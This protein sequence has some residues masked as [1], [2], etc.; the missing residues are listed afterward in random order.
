MSKLIETPDTIELTSKA[1]Q[2]ISRA[3]YAG[4][5]AYR[6][7]FQKITEDAKVRFEHA[8]WSD[9]QTAGAERLAIYHVH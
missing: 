3:I 9:V 7:D 5:R 1:V 8:Q 6:K 4:F 2:D